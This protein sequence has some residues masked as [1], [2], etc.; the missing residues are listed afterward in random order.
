MNT[1]TKEKWAAVFFGVFA[2]LFLVLG[3][4]NMGATLEGPK[5]EKATADAKLSYEVEEQFSSTL[6]TDGDGLT[7][8]EETSVY[9]TSA[10][11]ADSDSDGISDGEEVD[12]G[13]NP[14]CPRG[15]VC[16]RGNLGVPFSETPQAPDFSGT[17]QASGSDL[18]NIASGSQDVSIE[19][20]KQLLIDSGASEAEVNKIPENKL[21]ELY[22]ETA[23]TPEISQHQELANA[24][25]SQDPQKIREMLKEQGVAPD[26]LDQV[27]DEEL[28]EIFKSA[29]EQGL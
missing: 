5:K 7:D 4:K 3:V 9:E 20:I 6:D 27:S 25:L 14:L 8:L 23:G 17:I 2:L 21:R 22:A 28:K 26:V 11:I 1:A 13:E 16:T 18:S 19:E 29:F 15:R 12:L 24:L 10:Y